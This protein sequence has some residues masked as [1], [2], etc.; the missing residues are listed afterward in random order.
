MLLLAV[1]HG[2]VSLESA[3]QDL[4]HHVDAI[5]GTELARHISTGSACSTICFLYNRQNIHSISETPQKNVV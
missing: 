4:P 3:I 2:V 5:I 1:S